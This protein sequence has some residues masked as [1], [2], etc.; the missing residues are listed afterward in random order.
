MRKE[1]ST[2]F[3]NNVAMLMLSQVLIKILGFVYRLVMMHVDGFGDIGNGFYNAGFQIYVLL[4][5]ISSVGIPTVVSKLVAEKASKGDLQAAHR[6]FKISLAM[7]GALG[8]SFSVALFV[9]AQQVAVVVLN[10]PDVQYVLMALSPSIV[11]VAVSAVFRGYFAGLG[12]QKAAS[13]SRT[14]EQFFKC[15]LTIAIIYAFIGRE[16]YIMAAS[17]NL[18]TTLAVILS[19]SYL[20]MFYG[21]RRKAIKAEITASKVSERKEKTWT[22]MK[23]IMA[24]SIPITLGSLV[25]IVN[26]MIDTITISHSVQAFYTHL[27]DGCTEALR[28]EA[29]RLARDII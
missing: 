2:S 9:F 22:L 11:F 8:L 26:E 21:R 17:A 10:I 18:A 5:T 12:S 16:P 20:V 7:F 28:L 6:I 23:T 29:M 13:V 1:N 14:L 25:A 15:V 4:L 3:M 24:I 27:F 19:F